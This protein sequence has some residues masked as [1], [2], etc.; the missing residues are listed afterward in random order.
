MDI[1]LLS[2]MF[3]DLQKDIFHEY[4]SLL[5]DRLEQ[6]TD[7]K[8]IR[9]IIEH[10]LQELNAK[11]TLF[12]DKIDKVDYFAIKGSIRVFRENSL[13]GALIGDTSMMIF[14]DNALYYAVSND[15]DNPESIDLFS[16]FVEGEVLPGDEMILV[17]YDIHTVF[18]KK[19]LK[20]F[21][22]L[23]SLQNGNVM[24]FLEEIIGMRIDMSLA[25]YMIRTVCEAPKDKPYKK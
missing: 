2:D 24:D 6:E 21:N 20:K 10:T 8:H 13:I 7:E 9:R 11:L 19:E 4:F 17:G 22:E 23:Y 3:L 18:D 16:E 5:V 15:Y 12:A 1:A 25:T 14:R